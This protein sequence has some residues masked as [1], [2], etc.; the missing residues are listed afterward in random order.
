M[1]AM[2]VRERVS[3]VAPRIVL[4]CFIVLLS[5]VCG[6]ISCIACCVRACVCVCNHTMLSSNHRFQ[7]SLPMREDRGLAEQYLLLCGRI[8]RR[9]EVGDSLAAVRRVWACRVVL[10]GGIA[11]ALGPRLLQSGGRGLKKGAARIILTVAALLGVDA[12]RGGRFLVSPRSLARVGYTRQAIAGRYGSRQLAVPR[13]TVGDF[14]SCAGSHMRGCVLK[15]VGIELA[16]SDG[17]IARLI[18]GDPSL[19]APLQEG[20]RHC[21]HACRLLHRLRLLLPPE[22]ACESWGSLLHQ[23]YRDQSGA[24]AARLATRLFLK[25]ARLQCG[26]SRRDDL[27]VSAVAD[28]LFKIYKKRPHAKCSRLNETSYAFRLAS[29]PHGSCNWVA[30]AATPAEIFNSSRSADAPQYVP[31]QISDSLHVALDSRF[32]RDAFGQI[33]RDSEGMKIAQPLAVTVH[34]AQQRRKGHATSSIER[35]LRA[36]LTSDAGS[37]WAAK[38]EAMRSGTAEDDD[39][40]VAE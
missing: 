36:W 32:R 31:T 37:A 3:V 12:C 19:H 40:D 23:L 39:V 34:M 35:D 22:K 30:V 29:R 2:Y 26:G 1:Y 20:W 21:W 16:P 6:S 28:A 14:Y 9:W 38:R 33:R 10:P 17:K 27:V 7:S 15:V 13:L 18:D 8:R 5:V 4:F 11:A 25:E 24:S